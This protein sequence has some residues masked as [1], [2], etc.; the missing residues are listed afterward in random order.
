MDYLVSYQP[1]YRYLSPMG[2]D[3][4]TPFYDAGCTLIGLGRKFK[5]QVLHAVEIHDGE[6]IVDVGCATGVLLELAKTQYPH[7]RVI[8][9]DPD[10][11]ALAI[12][13]KR[14][15]RSGLNVELHQAF[16]ES[17]PLTKNSVDACFSSLA[18]HHMPD[19]VKRKALEE[20]QRVLK[21][22]GRVVIA[23]FGPAKGKWLRRLLFFWKIEYLKGNL[24][25]IIPRYIN[26][27]GFKK[28][29]ATGR[30]FPGIVIFTAKKV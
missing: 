2:P 27:V 18:F 10:R 25:G 17:L 23:D 29:A 1:N 19:D 20:M 28:L 16:A 11:K 30:Q 24:E 12:A 13:Q 4:L 6:T 8:G 21:P 3:W 15:E 9:I 14:V 22:G 5:E 7:S 26:E